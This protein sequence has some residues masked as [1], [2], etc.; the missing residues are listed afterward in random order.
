MINNL[1]LDYNLFSINS[2]FQMLIMNYSI[3]FTL[4]QQGEI[5]KSAWYFGSKK[6]FASKDTVQMQW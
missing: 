3:F 2:L 6:K 4:K 1:L 5:T